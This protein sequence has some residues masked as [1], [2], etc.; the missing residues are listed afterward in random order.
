MDLYI[1]CGSREANRN[2]A[3]IINDMTDW[4]EVTTSIWDGRVCVD[5]DNLSRESY[6]TQ[7][8]VLDIAASFGN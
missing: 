3:E 7:R 5:M 2:M 4:G 1:D 8:T 6:E